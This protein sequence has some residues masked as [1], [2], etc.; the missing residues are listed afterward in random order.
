[1]SC[2]PRP[3]QML[4]EQTAA[5]DRGAWEELRDRHCLELYAQV[6]AICGEA[7]DTE[8]VV[9][10]AFEQARRCARQFDL[11]GDINVAAWLAGLARSVILGRRSGSGRKSAARSPRK[12][13]LS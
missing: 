8:Q 2:L 3:D 7:A 13:N 12:A 10:E 1:M 5:G 9:A 4:L 11:S 6:F